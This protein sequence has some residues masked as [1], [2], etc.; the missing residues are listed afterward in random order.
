MDI[1]SIKN[2]YDS[3]YDKYFLEM[4]LK[5]TDDN[6]IRMHF[7][8]NSYEDFA[9]MMLRLIETTNEKRL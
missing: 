8:E 1:V 2:G 6:K 4:E 9:K 7:S 3:E 5:G